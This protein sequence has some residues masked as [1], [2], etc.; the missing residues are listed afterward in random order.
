ML[1][2]AELV[3][4]Y[5]NQTNNIYDVVKSVSDVMTIKI[6]TIGMEDEAQSAAKKMRSKNVSS[7]VVVDKNDQ[8]VG[9]VTERDVVREVCAQ[10]GNSS[11]YVIHQIMS[12]PIVTI[13]PNSSV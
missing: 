6:E 9:I 2:Q 5:K 8:A 11:Q 12:S 7:L 3:I 4:N 1:R 13:D 10:D